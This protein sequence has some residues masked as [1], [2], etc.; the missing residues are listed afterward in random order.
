MPKIVYVVYQIEYVVPPLLAV[1]QPLPGNDWFSLAAFG[2]KAKFRRPRVSQVF[3]FSGGL[4]RPALTIPQPHPLP[5]RFICFA[6]FAVFQLLSLSFADNCQ[7]LP[8]LVMLLDQDLKW[9][10]G[11]TE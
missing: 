8:S 3:N 2:H 6:F 7:S 11:D 9:D 4:W 1:K 5:S 10:S